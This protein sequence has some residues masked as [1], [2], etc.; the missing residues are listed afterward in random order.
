MD[1]H[2]KE[3][4]Y[5]KR[6]IYLLGKMEEKYDIVWVIGEG[7]GNTLEALY[8]VEYCLQQQIKAGVILKDLGNSF[9]SYLKSCYGNIILDETRPIKTKHLIHSWLV[10]QSFEV[11]YDHY[12]YINPDN[13]SSQFLSEDEQY[14][15]V[16]R[17]LYPSP[18]ESHVLTKLIEEQPD[19][20]IDYKTKHILYAGCSKPSPSKRWPHFNS[21]AE[22]LSKD[23]V[24]FIGGPD[25]IDFSFSFTYPN[26]VGK[27]L[28]KKVTNR[29][30]FWKL[31]KRFGILKKYAQYH[32]HLDE[33]VSSRIGV[34]SW[35]QLVYVLRHS[36]GFFGNDGGLSHLAGASGAKGVVVF[37]PSSIKKS[38]PFSHRITSI[39][40][41]LP[42]QPCLFEVDGI[43][44][45]K[46]YINC[47]YSVKCLKDIT[48][49]EVI[50]TWESNSKTQQD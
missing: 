50:S 38:H 6:Q 45:G 7:I 35:P 2:R 1:S 11:E 16:V 48:V 26:I 14:L 47:P 22:R 44:M 27:L 23:E 34:F 28:P 13:L 20:S 41:N 33:S 12:F 21:L 25:D 30:E 24:V 39:S 49:D 18:Y 40:K 31:L 9:I 15:S 32:Y 29:I 36:K 8:S 19:D 5:S 17:A 42:C 4:S 10:E 3:I 43:H 37:G 46:N